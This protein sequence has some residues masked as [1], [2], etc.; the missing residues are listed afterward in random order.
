MG[1]FRNSVMKCFG[2]NPKHIPKDSEEMMISPLFNKT[3]GAGAEARRQAF[4]SRSRLYQ[5]MDDRAARNNRRTKSTPTGR[6][7]LLSE[8]LPTYA[9]KPATNYAVKPTSP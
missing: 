6:S 3:Y 1:F 2:I 9:T 7:A 4:S 5:Q 8:N